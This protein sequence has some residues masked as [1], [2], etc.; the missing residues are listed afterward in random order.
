[1]LRDN[2]IMLL[3]CG[4]LIIVKNVRLIIYSFLTTHLESLPGPP[5]WFSGQ[6]CWLW[7]LIDLQVKKPLEP[8]LC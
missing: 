6:S 1:M 8:E 4:K 5:A 3:K 2:Y 7:I